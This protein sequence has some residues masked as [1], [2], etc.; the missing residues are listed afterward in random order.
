[1]RRTLLSCIASLSVKTSTVKCF[2]TDA[3]DLA[4]RLCAPSQVSYVSR[5]FLPKRKPL[6]QYKYDYSVLDDRPYTHKPLYLPRLGGRDPATG[7]KVN[8]HV[9]GGYKFEFT[10]ISFD[11]VGPTDG[12]FYDERV[13]EVRC[14]PIETAHVALVAGSRGRRWILATENMKAGDLI[15]TTCTIPKMPV[16]GKEGD[17]WPVGALVAGTMVNCVELYPGEGK[18]YLVAKNAGTFVTITRKINDMVVIQLQSKAELCIKPE[19]M[20]TV[21]RLSNLDYR[22]LEW[23]SIHMKR[24]FGIKQASG[25]WHRKDGYAG[26]KIKPVPPMRVIDSVKKQEG[27]GRKDAAA[28]GYSLPIDQYRKQIGRHQT[29]RARSDVKIMK[30]RSAQKKLNLKSIKYGLLVQVPWQNYT[31]EMELNYWGSKSTSM[32]SINSTANQDSS[33]PFS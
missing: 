5:R 20:A 32:S 9:G 1:M 15:R 12:T 6:P 3:T 26:R 21:G 29:K 31:V 27:M 23:G 2:T 7:R 16:K 18:D 10:W 11:R 19:C 14:D 22:K 13:L 24:R 17:S 25:L 28:S 33:P 30:Q 4:I 8:Q